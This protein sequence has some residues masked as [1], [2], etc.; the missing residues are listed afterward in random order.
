MASIR[1]SKITS[2]GRVTIPV[3]IREELGFRPGDVVVFEELDG[4]LAFRRS[5]PGED[6]T[7]ES[8]PDDEVD[9]TAGIL[10]EYA[11][12]RNPDPA[13]ERRW[14]ARHIAET[15]DRDD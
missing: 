10:S 13:E 15:A 6:Q 1:R 11:Y 5:E 9:L 4:R 12:T 2:N 3:E 8:L 14:V 7:S